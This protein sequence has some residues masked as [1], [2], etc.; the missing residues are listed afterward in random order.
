MDS[1]TKYQVCL[2][3]DGIS[4]YWDKSA[5][6]TRK[7]DLPIEFLDSHIS[8]DG[9]MDMTLDE[10]NAVFRFFGA[11]KPTENELQF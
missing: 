7:L 5:G 9:P 4:V 8:V 3:D 10:V 2:Y 6:I 1:E 11:E